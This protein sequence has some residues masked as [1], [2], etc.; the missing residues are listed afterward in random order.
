MKQNNERDSRG[1]MN[2]DYQNDHLNR[3]RTDEIITHL[4]WLLLLAFQIALFFIL[5]SCSGGGSSGTGTTVIRGQ[6]FSSTNTPVANAELTVISTGDSATTDAEGNFV[7]E[8][9]PQTGS[10]ELEIATAA[11]TDSITIN[12]PDGEASSLNIQIT[13]DE[14]QG[15]IVSVDHLEIS[16]GIY[17][18]CDRF[19]ENRSIIRQSNALAVGTECTVKVWVF[20][21]GKPLDDIPFVLEARGCAGINPWKIEAAGKTRETGVGQL[22][23]IYKND[24]PHCEYR[25]IVPYNVLGLQTTI[26]PI[27]TYTKQKYDRENK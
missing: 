5:T 18:A 2:S 22:S 24:A 8:T 25:I 20:G 7:I 9:A 16:A 3:S 10:V 13:L 27:H 23:F 26:Y 12:D 21:D 17:G 11:G 6:V 19:F 14:S 4:W 1:S 15:A